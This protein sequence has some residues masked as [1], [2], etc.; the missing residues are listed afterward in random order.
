[1]DDAAS[2]CREVLARLYV[3]LDGEFASA[4]CSGIEIHLR[5]CEDCLHHADFERDLKELV[6]RKCGEDAP[7]QLVER[8]RARLREMI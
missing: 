1:M 3:Y 6:R 8:L 4:D 2:D 7:A 5:D